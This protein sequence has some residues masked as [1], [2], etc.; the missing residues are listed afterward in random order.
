MS[1]ALAA[2][3]TVIGLLF[4]GHG[5]QKLFG[6]F[7]GHGPEGTGSFFDSIGMRPGKRMAMAAG[8]TELGGGTLLTLGLATPLA[9]TGLTSVMCSA[10]WTVHRPNGLWIDKG[11]FEY[12][13]VVTSALFTIAAAGPGALSLDRALGAERS[14]LGWA[15]ASL[16]AGVTGAAAAIVAGRSV[17]GA[18]GDAEAQAAPAGGAGA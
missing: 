3:R 7:G 13:L 10:G 17:D 11:G 16:A 18:P 4:I 6:A 12:H 8:A 15:V 2:L 9:T 14:G 1:L 5:A